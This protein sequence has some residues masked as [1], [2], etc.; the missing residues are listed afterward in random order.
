MMCLSAE[1]WSALV[2]ATGVVVAIIALIAESRRS[3]F[4]QGVAVI[5][6]LNDQFDSSEFRDTRAWAAGYLAGPD[7]SA[8]GYHAVKDVLN[9]FEALAY[10][11]RKGVVDLEACSHFFSAFAI[12]YWAASSEYRIKLVKKD[13][14]VFS[15]AA[16]F[17][18]KL[19]A[20]ED[21]ATPH[22]AAVLISADAIRTFLANE[23][24]AAGAE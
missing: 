6:R 1:A 18:A 20:H 24:Q 21:A 2:S 17:V 12:P 23:Q 10:L 11:H 16:C 5:M 7:R 15:E 8:V 19:E 14:R 3:R 13:P 22:G 4:A 9:F